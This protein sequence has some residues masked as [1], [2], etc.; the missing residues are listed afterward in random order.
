MRAL[1]LAN[2]VYWVGAIDWNLRD[3]HGYNTRRGTTYNAYLVVDEKTA[4]IDTVK[5]GF[6]DEMLARIRTVMDPADLDYV[7]ANHTELDHSGSEPAILGLA[8]KATLVA[9]KR[10]GETAQARHFHAGW[11]I[12]PVSEGSSINLGKR[13]LQFVPIPMLHWPDSMVTY[14]PEEQIL[15]SND[16]FGQHLA[17]SQMFDD[18]VDAAIV[19]GE[20]KQYYATILMPFGNLITRALDKLGGLPITTIA[21]SHGVIW[22]GDPGR[23]LSAYAGWARGDYTRKVVIAY[24]SMWESTH[25][26]AVRIA[27]GM[28]A[29]LVDIRLLD[30]KACHITEVLAE[31][32]DARMLLVGSA[33]INNGMLAPVGGLLTILKGLKPKGKLGVAFGSYGWSGGAVKA[34]EAELQ[35]AGVEIAEPGVAYSF[36]PDETELQACWE[37]GRR[38]GTRI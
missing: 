38:L 36:V 14:L 33:T 24:D 32:L 3:F 37:L 30:L 11:E 15:F 22:R 7:I 19:M 12:E 34:I 13:T 8:K 18:E 21:P 10:A 28:A 9:S 1:E 16:A 29:E 25:K 2:G 6:T 5:A 26:M 20:A 27:D 23:I 4:L 35:V 31:L 17:T